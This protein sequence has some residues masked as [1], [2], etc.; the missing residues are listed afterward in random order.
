MTYLPGIIRKLGNLILKHLIYRLLLQQLM[1]SLLMLPIVQQTR[2]NLH[3]LTRLREAPMSTRIEDLLF[4]CFGARDQLRPHNMPVHVWV[5]LPI[6]G[7]AGVHPGE[8][9]AH[10]VRGE[11]VD[12]LQA[13]RL[14]DVLLEV[15]VERHVGGAFD[16]LAGPVDVDAV[17]PAG[18]RLV[19]ERLG[20]ELVRVAREFVQPRGAV[21]G[22]KLGVEERVAEASCG[23]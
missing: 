1:P 8:V 18:A 9:F 6:R 19:D 20:E 14:E 23:G 7:V 4:L 5:D 3:I 15:V 12:V 2:N 21:V 11:H 17:F 16:Q 13:Q 22:E 10:R